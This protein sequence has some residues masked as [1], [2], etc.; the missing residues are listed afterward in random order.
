MAQTVSNGLKR[1]FKAG[2]EAHH[3]NG[4][5]GEMLSTKERPSLNGLNEIRF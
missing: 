5:N 3:L 2:E 4:S 1:P